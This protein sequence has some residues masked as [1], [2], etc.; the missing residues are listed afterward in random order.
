MK[1]HHLFIN[2]AICS[3]HLLEQDEHTEEEEDS[4]KNRK[5]KQKTWSNPTRNHSEDKKF[6]DNWA[7]K[8]KH[9]QHEKAISNN[10]WAKIWHTHQLSSEP[11]SKEAFKLLHTHDWLI[12]LTVS[13]S[14]LFAIFISFFSYIPILPNRKE[15]T[16]SNKK[17]KK[18]WQKG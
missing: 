9:K 3:Q 12:S 10:E 6:G 2:T 11:K 18:N 15:E 8:M 7:W 5:T 4:K 14:V 17:A 13:L 1:Y 16:F